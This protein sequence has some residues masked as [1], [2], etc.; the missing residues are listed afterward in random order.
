MTRAEFLSRV[1]ERM[2]FSNL[3]DAE[4]CVRNVLE[5]VGE[6]LSRLEAEALAE[7]LPADLAQ[8][9][10]RASHGQTFGIEEFYARISRRAGMGIGR[11]REEAVV[12]CWVMA[13][14][15]GEDALQ[16]IRRELPREFWELFTLPEPIPPPATVH[17][18]PEHRTLAEGHG[19]G[20]R[21]LYDARPDRAQ[22]QSVAR[23]DNPHGDTKVSSATGLTQEREE[24]TLAS[25][26]PGS[27]RPLSE[28]DTG[29]S[30]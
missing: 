27:E 24:E 28:A 16:R 7:D 5:T 3:A 22:S 18:H 29:P 17:L 21:P 25:G 26:R 10:R 11:A 2:G 19:G 23:S 4:T 14:A 30:R 1:A 15:V 20:S 6:R 9:L 8:P 13:E 12:V